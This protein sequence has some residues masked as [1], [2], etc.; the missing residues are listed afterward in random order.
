MP[1]LG[2]LRG[3]EQRR[4]V[5]ARPRAQQLI[6]RFA[7]FQAWHHRG[8]VDQQQMWL[9]HECPSEH[10]PHAL[11]HRKRRGEV[12][13]PIAGA[14]PGQGLACPDPRLVH[15][16]PVAHQRQCH[17]IHDPLALGWM[18]VFA[19]KQSDAVAQQPLAPQQRHPRQVV[20]LE[21]DPSLV[22]RLETCRQPQ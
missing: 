15:G 10:H 4:V 12:V 16:G 19:C 13:R 21:D 1:G 18:P 20:A 2:V 7:L 9:A 3:D 11:A 8:L 22:G 6:Q 17:E 5:L 14:R